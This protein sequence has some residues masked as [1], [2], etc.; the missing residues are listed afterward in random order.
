MYIL[1][2][3]A[4]NNIGYGGFHYTVLLSVFD[5]FILINAYD[6]LLQFADSI[7]HCKD[8]P[9]ELLHNPKQ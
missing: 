6:L 7:P 5:I 3:G 4:S 8:W 9:D 2:K 1:V